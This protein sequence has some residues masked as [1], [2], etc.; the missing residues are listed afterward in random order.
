LKSNKK[1]INGALVLLIGSIWGSSFLFIKILTPTVGPMVL[2]HL[3][4]L[5]ASL[6][7]APFFIRKRHLI[8]F[9]NQLVPIILLALFNAI[10]PFYLFSVASLQLTASTLAIL[11]GIT[12]L[13]TFILSVLWLKSDY[14]F[15]QLLGIV[16]GITGLYVFVGYDSLNFFLLPVFLCLL[17]TSMYA[18]GTNYLSILKNLEPTYIA[19]MTLLTGA[20]LTSPVLFINTGYSFEWSIELLVLLFLIGAMCTGL[21]YVC[22]V[23]LIRR[24]GPVVTS[25]TLLVVPIFGMIWANIFLLESI[26]ITMILGCILIIGGVSLTNFF[27][28]KE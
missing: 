10:L 27:S 17:A 24:A 15:I 23:L 18:F 3:R 13:F 25:T 22:Y 28:K 8:N 11:N 6:F 7:L 14:Q 1:L 19:T 2:V 26:T 9:K 5:I 4:L 20:L 12:P 16:L 21:A